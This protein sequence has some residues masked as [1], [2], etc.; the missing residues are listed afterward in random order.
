[1]RVEHQLQGEPVLEAAVRTVVLQVCACVSLNGLIQADPGLSLYTSL[2]ILKP[3]GSSEDG[4]GTTGVSIYCTYI[5]LL[6]KPTAAIDRLWV[7]CLRQ[8][9]PLN[10]SQ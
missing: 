1:V 8:W 9:Q 2:L 4:G 6:C 5:L 7:R 3:G 10:H